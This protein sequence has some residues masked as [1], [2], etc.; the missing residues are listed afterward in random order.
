MGIY[1][2]LSDIINSNMHAMLDK[3]EDPEK[4]IRLIIQE[5]E[6]T[7]VEVR[8]TSVRTIA[9]RK[10]LERKR[11]TL[12]SDAAEWQRKAELALAHERED[13]ARAALLAKARI[14]DVQAEIAHELEALDAQQ[15]SLD[16]DIGKLKAKLSDAK[17]R[18]KSIVMRKQSASTRI[19]VQQQV[20]DDKINDALAQFETYERRIDSLE[21]EAESY[22]LGSKTLNDE[23]AELEST[24]TVEAELAELKA[25]VRGTSSAN[26]DANNTPSQG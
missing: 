7:L 23:F 10:T 5:M 26:A 1:S 8:S 4:M 15:A 12:A 18:Q 20:H 19:R 3:A 22:D 14:T 24:D 2:R 6:D 13:L 17:A 21:A 16:T 9:R 25:R 11:Q